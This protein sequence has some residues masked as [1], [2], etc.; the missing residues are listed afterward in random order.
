MLSDPTLSITNLRCEYKTNPIGIDARP[1]RLSWE[2]DS[3]QR[4]AVRSAYQVRVA[5]RA[6]SAL[7]W[8]A[9]SRNF[10]SRGGKSLPVAV[11]AGLVGSFQN[12]VPF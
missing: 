7:Q 10:W 5:T 2:L 1:P 12:S 8:S 6:A 11:R 4:G 9:R 3:P